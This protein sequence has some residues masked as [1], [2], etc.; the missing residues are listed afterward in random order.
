[1]TTTEFRDLLSHVTTW[2][3]GQ[4]LNSDLEA[5]LNREFPAGGPV[6]EAIFDACRDAM[7]TGWMCYRDAGGIRFGRVIKPDAA[8]SHFSVDVVEMTDLAGPQHRHPHGEIDLIMPLTPGATFDGRPAG[9]LVYGPDSSHAPTV[10][11]GTAWVL[12]L[13]PQ[14]AIEFTKS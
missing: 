11:G 9:W 12:Y 5:R 8:L 13:L 4:A 10:A 2:V 3:E 7:A 14:G 6:T 1:M